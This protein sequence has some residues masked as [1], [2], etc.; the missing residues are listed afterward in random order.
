MKIKNQ[1]LA[2]ALVLT[3]AGIQGAQATI[4]F[5]DAPNEI[6][7]DSVTVIR[8]GSGKFTG[9]GSTGFF[10]F[11]ANDEWNQEVNIYNNVG[12]F[13]M[14]LTFDLNDTSDP[15]ISS[16]D[17]G[18]NLLG[19][20]SQ[21]GNAGIQQVYAMAIKGSSPESLEYAGYVYDTDF[22]TVA[23]SDPFTM[24]DANDTNGNQLDLDQSR[25]VAAAAVPEPSALILLGL[26]S[27]AAFCRRKRA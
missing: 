3:L 24:G 15:Y 17:E 27:L 14:S 9:F 20:T 25:A 23:T 16:L 22:S 13:D 12:D 2:A 11:Q 18:I 21:I 19:I 4:I 1:S 5:V 10:G 26:G 6:G 8:D 7:P